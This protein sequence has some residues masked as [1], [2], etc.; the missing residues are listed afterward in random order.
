M[1]SDANPVQ[2]PATSLV[3]GSQAPTKVTIQPPSGKSLPP[4]GNSAAETAKS[5][6]A[7]GVSR[8]SDVQAQVAF[9]NKY[10]ND[11]GKP[12][13]FQ[14]APNSNSTLIQEV[15]PATG[16]VIADYPVSVFPELAKSLGI[17]S[18]LIDERA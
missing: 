2:I 9:L 14:V 17:S 16:E 12:D 4:S 6:A 3:H 13:R 1:A 10:L 15:N 18:A 5:T 11:S 7:G 8:T